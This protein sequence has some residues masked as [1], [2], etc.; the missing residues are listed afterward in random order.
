MPALEP[1]CNSVFTNLMAAAGIGVL[2]L[3]ILLVAFCCLCNL[4]TAYDT[5]APAPEQ[6]QPRPRSRK[7]PA[8]AGKPSTTAAASR[9]TALWSECYT[10]LYGVW[11]PRDN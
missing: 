3:S 8:A 5:F 9:P 10:C 11:I 7:V 6:D 1:I 2:V 4:S